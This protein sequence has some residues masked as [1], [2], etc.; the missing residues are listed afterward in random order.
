[1][2]GDKKTKEGEAAASEKP[3]AGK[4]KLIIIVVAVLLLAGSAGGW[5]FMKS[6]AADTEH[7][8]EGHAKKEKKARVFLPMDP[9]TVNLA[10]ENNRFAQV[11][12]VYDVQNA[13]TAELIKNI[14]PAVRDRVLR[15]ISA[16]QSA[17]LLSNNGKEILAQEIVE[18]TAKL[19]G[20]EPD[21]PKVTKKKVVAKS[22]DADEESEDDDEAGDEAEDAKPKK[23]SSKASSKKGKSKSRK[24]ANPN[25]IN[26]VHFA[27][28]IIQ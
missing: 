13:E 25:P 24:I 19:I 7:A 9:F 10:G 20:W 12:I 3:K 15:L 16:K 18:E 22:K 4:K 6:R 17:T 21:E 5:F 14:M 27:Q 23:S 8:D 26:E 2:A 1:M 28:F 11:A